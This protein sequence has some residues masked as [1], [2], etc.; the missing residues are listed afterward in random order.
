MAKAIN[1]KN[2]CN[3][4]ISPQAWSRIVL[5]SIPEIR[6]IG[7]EMKDLDEPKDNLNLDEDVMKLLSKSLDDLYQMKIESEVLS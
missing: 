4:N 3:Q 2:W 5:R 1:F 6:K 7:L